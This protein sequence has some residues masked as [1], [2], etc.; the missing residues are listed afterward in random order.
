VEK[1]WIQLRHEEY[2]QMKGIPSAWLVCACLSFVFATADSRT[3]LGAAK[4]TADSRVSDAKVREFEAALAAVKTDVDGIKKKD[5]DDQVAIKSKLR[6]LEASTASFKADVEKLKKDDSSWLKIVLPIIAPLIAAAALVLSCVQYFK[7]VPR[8]KGRALLDWP[9]E[10]SGHP[11]GLPRPHFRLKLRNETDSE[12][13]LTKVVFHLKSATGKESDVQDEFA[14]NL[15]V[16]P[17]GQ[18]LERQIPVLKILDVVR[19]EA[20]SPTKAWDIEWNRRYARRCA[21]FKSIKTAFFFNTRD[22]NEM[23]LDVFQA[24]EAFYV[25]KAGYSPSIYDYGFVEKHESEAAALKQFE[26]ERLKESEYLES[27]D[28]KFCKLSGAQNYFRDYW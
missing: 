18:S 15:L 24:G 1:S 11:P 26:H 14:E 13:K 10:R 23:V 19:V 4:D 5:D 8:T 28:S 6:E 9:I 12:V 27:D 2:Q 22:L 3:T 7:K 17:S 16:L 20:H 25:R 21:A